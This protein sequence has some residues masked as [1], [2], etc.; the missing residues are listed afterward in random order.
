MKKYQVIDERQK[1]NS[2]ATSLC[3]INIG[4]TADYA[5]YLYLSARGM[6]TPD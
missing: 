2:I 6:V 3:T 5:F 4:Q 1:K